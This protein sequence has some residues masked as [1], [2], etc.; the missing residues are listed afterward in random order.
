MAKKPAASKQP[1]PRDVR[2]SSLET[3]LRFQQA[4]IEKL[5]GDLG[6]ANR[7]NGR[8]LEVGKQ[9]KSLA[10]EREATVNRLQSACAELSGQLFELRGY[11]RAVTETVDRYEGRTHQPAPALEPIRREM[12]ADG[13]AR[14][15]ALIGSSSKP[16]WRA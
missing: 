3:K 4:Q 2:I 11:A 6:E 14:N 16:W 8:L 7:E 5:T 1:D 9:W 13:I 15:G 12:P 10:E